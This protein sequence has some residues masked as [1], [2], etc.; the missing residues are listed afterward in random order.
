M[1][2]EPPKSTRDKLVRGI[3]L[4]GEGSYETAIHYGCTEKEAREYAS[5]MMTALTR[6]GIKH[7]PVESIRRRMQK[8]RERGKPC[9]NFASFLRRD[10]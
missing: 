6:E 2:N 8:E 1:K 3:A 4:V 10:D 5:K 7:I 9:P